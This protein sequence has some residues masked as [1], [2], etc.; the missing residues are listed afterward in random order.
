MKRK[1][2]VMDD[3][4]DNFIV[5]GVLLPYGLHQNYPNPFN[6]NT[7]IS[8]KME[9]DCIGTLV[10]YNLKGEKTETLFE[11]RE[12]TADEKDYLVSDSTDKN[13]NPGP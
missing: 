11:N 1:F 7:S 3:P 8:Y 5:P 2:E 6:P 10:I 9:K 13:S 12:M 4:I